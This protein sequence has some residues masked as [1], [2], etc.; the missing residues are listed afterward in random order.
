M[1][2]YIKR[3]LYS[4]WNSKPNLQPYNIRY[5]TACFWTI[6]QVLLVITPQMVPSCQWCERHGITVKGRE[7]DDI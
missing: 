1:I 3:M 2:E 6:Y 5:K 4:G 7:L